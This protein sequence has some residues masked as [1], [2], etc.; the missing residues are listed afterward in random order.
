[1]SERVTN[2]DIDRRVGRLEEVQTTH[3]DRLHELG[4]QVNLIGL[5][6]EHSEKLF[7]SKFDQVFTRLDRLI[8]RTEREAV[9]F[10]E[11]S[12]SPAGRVADKRLA[13]LEEGRR[14]NAERIKRVEERILQASAVIAF[15]AFL[16]PLLAPLIQG[17]I[18][19]PR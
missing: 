9:G 5:K 4:N 8:E 10:A 2:Q 13:E 17:W 15:V 19:L 16:T 18:G 7:S 3:G 14:Q 12:A 1:M 6:Q 11:L